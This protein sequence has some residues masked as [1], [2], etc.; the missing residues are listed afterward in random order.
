[1]PGDDRVLPAPLED[2]A[3]AADVEGCQFPNERFKH[4]EHIRLAW[5]Y[6]RQYGYDMAEERMRQSIRRLAVHAGAQAKYHET[7]TIAWMR[8]VGAALRLSARM[9][10]F[11]EFS[12]AHAWLLDKG[13]VFEFYSRDRLMSEGARAAWIDP[14]LKPLPNR[15]WQ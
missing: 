3:F 6:I 15:S 9:E 1:M 8:L 10:T 5:I 13:A 4:A 7:I 14:D 11:S 2:A 12:R